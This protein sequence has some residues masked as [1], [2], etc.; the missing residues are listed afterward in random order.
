MVGC[1]AYSNFK[2][3]CKLSFSQSTIKKVFL[4]VQQSK[5]SKTTF[6]ELSINYNYNLT[7]TAASQ[8]H[9]KKIIKKNTII[10][11]MGLGFYPFFSE[12]STNN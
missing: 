10:E 11:S 7:D 8:T 9:K 1:H 3:S 6:F 4:I 12:S 2:R 5:L